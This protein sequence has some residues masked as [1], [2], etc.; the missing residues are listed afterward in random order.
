[1]EA[2]PD[3]G[4]IL[5]VD[6]FHIDPDLE[7]VESLRNRTCSRMVLMLAEFL[8]SAPGYH[9]VEYRVD[10]P[11]DRRS[12]KWTRKPFTRADLDHLCELTPDMSAE[13][14]HR[15]IRAT[16]YPGK[17]GAVLKINGL[18]FVPK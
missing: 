14:M 8:R 18:E 12:V 16:T 2:T 17:P 6:R 4:K 9:A 15:V 3:T 7:T 13:H 5:A 10:S 1:M 11:W